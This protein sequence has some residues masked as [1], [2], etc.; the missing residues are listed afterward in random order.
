MRPLAD[1][2]VLSF[3]H[4][5]AGPYAGRLLA[6]WGADVVK[7]EPPGGATER[8]DSEQHHY[9]CNRGKRSLCVDLKTDDGRDMIRDLVG[10]YDVVFENYRP[11]T[12]EGLGL[13]YEALRTENEALVYCSLSG[14]GDS[15]PYRNRPAMDPIAQAMSGL[16][17][18]TGEPDRR[19]SRIGGSI[20][21][22]GTATN[23]VLA[24][25]LAVYHRERTGEGR[26]VEAS[27]LETAYGWA[28]E[29][30][31]FYTLFDEEPR[32]LGDKVASYAPVGAYETDDDD[33]VYI[34]AYG[35][36]L[37]RRL[38]DVLELDGVPEDPRFETDANRRE[39]RE[40]IDNRIES[41]TA[42]YAADEL[43]DRL[44][45]AGIPAARIADVPEVLNDE[46]LADRNMF[47]DV[48]TDDGREV[49]APGSPMK[50]HGS[51]PRAETTA[52]GLGADNVAVLREAGY[53]PA[54]IATLE[55]DGVLQGGDG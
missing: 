40:A 48:R 35:R 28:G 8:V 37:F 26:K 13:G 17:A 23:A 9:M 29:W 5:V 31:T 50:L 38:C 52:V 12:L 19:P 25:M 53:T 42:E 49:V 4:A 6:D 1:L 24:I 21:D 10:E 3:E 36:R 20:I 14:F 43:M 39:H 54:E 22:Y 11:G 16:M 55:A 45:D 27:L 51:E 41:A 46:H 18:M 7:V 33:L 32:R 2:K 34:S 30:S 47:V 44:L 15:G